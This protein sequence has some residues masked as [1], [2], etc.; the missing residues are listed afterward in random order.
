M[1]NK[2]GRKH[3]QSLPLNECSMPPIIKR[4]FRTDFVQFLVPDFFLVCLWEK[5]LSTHVGLEMSLGAAF[6]VAKDRAWPA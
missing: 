1:Q 4:W 5:G 3:L 6:V 2:L